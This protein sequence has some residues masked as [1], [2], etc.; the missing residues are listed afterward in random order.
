MCDIKKLQRQPFYSL[1][2]MISENIYSLGILTY[3]KQKKRKT[4]SGS[5]RLKPD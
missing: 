2:S 4:C 1:G 3:N 5:E